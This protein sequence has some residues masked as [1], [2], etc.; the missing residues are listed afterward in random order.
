MGKEQGYCPGFK[1]SLSTM[2][3]EYKHWI[4]GKKPEWPVD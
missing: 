1:E 3:M 4:Y 2:E